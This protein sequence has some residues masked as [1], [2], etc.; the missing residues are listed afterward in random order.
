MG[1]FLFHVGFKPC[2][3]PENRHSKNS[4]NSEPDKSKIPLMSALKLS[5]EINA[6]LPHLASSFP[7]MQAHIW[8]MMSL[9]QSSY[10]G[11]QQFCWFKTH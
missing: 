10:R 2:T 9:R 1:E 4:C 5:P 6:L 3:I 7:P 8:W 11:K